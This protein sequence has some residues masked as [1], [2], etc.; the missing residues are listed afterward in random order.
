MMSSPT[1]I[2]V[3][4]FEQV[5]MRDIFGLPPI[6]AASG[7]I[8]SLAPRRKWESPKTTLN[9]DAITEESVEIR[10]ERY[11]RAT[12][13]VGARAVK[14]LKEALREK[15]FQRV[16][17][18]PFQLRRNFKLFDK[19]GDGTID[20][21]E[22]FEC[23]PLLGFTL[24][25]D[26]VI[27]LFG[28]YD[29]DASGTM[30]Y[31]EFIDYVMEEPLRG[32]WKANDI[33]L[34][35]GRPVNRKARRWEVPPHNP[36]FGSD[37]DSKASCVGGL[38]PKKKI[39]SFADLNATKLNFK[40]VFASPSKEDCVR[41]FDITYFVA[42]DSIMIFEPAAQNSGI[43]AGRF[44]SRTTRAALDDHG[45]ATERCMFYIGATIHYAGRSFLVTSMN[46]RTRSYMLAHPDVWPAATNGSQ[47]SGQA[48][49]ST[50]SSPLI[51]LAH[52]GFGL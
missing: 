12:R 24:P 40:A 4:P 23:L 35:S 25:E 19:N 48:G 28:S 20:L 41:E 50:D 49:K 36:L 45:R 29:D 3:I 32:D 10:R 38:V 52:S 8:G 22:F 5:G 44:L 37:E 39:R 26:H 31:R 21:P 14:K 42:D 27:A 47:S 16:K 13:M 6:D 15:I 1:P 34:I 2:F 43:V 18:G 46:T 9:L 7:I 51:P 11:A 33:D 30:E 17:A